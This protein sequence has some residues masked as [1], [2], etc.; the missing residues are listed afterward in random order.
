MMPIPDLI[1]ATFELSGGYFVFRHCQETMRVKSV[2]G[3]SFLSL[4]FFTFWGIWNLWYYPHLGQWASFVGGIAIT[5]AN[6][7]WIY[8]IFKYR[9][10]DTAFTL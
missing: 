10:K 7:F 2:K 1:N 6:M 4:I 5:V 8:L 9:N 3:V